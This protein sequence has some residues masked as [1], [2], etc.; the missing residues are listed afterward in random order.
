MERQVRH[1][2]VYKRQIQSDHVDHRQ[3]GAVSLGG[4]HGDL[5]AGP[6]VQHIVR[7]V[8][9]GAA[10]HVDNGEHPAATILGHAQGGQGICRFTGLADDDDQR[11]VVQNG[12]PVPELTR[13]V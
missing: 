9:D 11:L 5:R 3:L 1:R 12:V 7:L 10:H 8:G 2:D 6:S 13:C 4:G